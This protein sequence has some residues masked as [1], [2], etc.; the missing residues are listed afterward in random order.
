MILTKKSG[1]MYFQYNKENSQRYRKLLSLL[2]SEL[3]QYGQEHVDECSSMIVT[4]IHSYQSLHG[5]SGVSCSLS[6][7]MD[8]LDMT[9]QVITDKHVEDILRRVDHTYDEYMTD[10][11]DR[12]KLYQWV[13]RKALREAYKS[14]STAYWLRTA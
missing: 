4:I 11:S 13:N 5:T 8:T 9:P 7:M 14:K 1:V 2:G 12:V 3:V 6:H 10:R